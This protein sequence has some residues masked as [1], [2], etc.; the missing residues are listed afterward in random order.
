LEALVSDHIDGPRTTADPS[1]DLSDLFVFKNPFDPRRLVL[2]ADVF[3][4]AG[5]TALFSNVANHNIVLRRIRVAG[6]G[7]ATSFVPEGPEIRFTFQFETLTPTPSGERGAQKGVCKLPDGQALQ[8]VVGD[9]QGA[10]SDGGAVR[11]F[12]GL[13][14]DPFYI[15]WLLGRDLK[16]VPNYLQ[17]DNVLSM[18]VEFDV[19]RFLQ[20]ENGSLFGAIAETAFRDPSPQ[21]IV[22][23]RFDWIGKP[24]QT[25]LRLNGIAGATDLRDLW[26]QET[27]FAIS[28]ATAP[29][30]RERLTRSLELWD[31]RDGK[32]DWEPDALAAN[33]N[34]FLSDFLLFDVAKPITDASHLEIEKSTVDGRPYA[35]GGGR[36]LDANSIDIMV[37][38]LV[39]HDRGPFMQGGAPHA[40]KPGGQTFPYVQPPNT[41][42]LM[43]SRSV[44]LAVSPRDVWS[45]VGKF[46]V[47]TWHPLVATVV[48][49]GI[50][51]GQVR[52]VD[53]IDG[54]VII[55]RLKSIDDGK[56]QLAY[57]LVSGLP[58]TH[59]E[60]TIDVQ[61]K[62]SGATVTWQVRYR[63]DGLADLFVRTALTGLLTAGL[64]NLK[65]RF[66]AA[67]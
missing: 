1:I 59:Y 56:M 5:E 15:G 47:L 38:W 50:G 39:N 37:T 17:E 28:E 14:S 30:Y 66:G 21:Q 33:V 24:E 9:E 51:I 22:P 20:T 64:G 35:T 3:P 54:K 10:S 18:V 26:N 40:T 32:V 63:P 65:A 67:P 6:I 19:G 36:T 41:S 43:I 61:P 49:T 48:T 16:S 7:G 25:N 45:V 2:V 42:L 13:R 62:G 58:A 57:T 29:L 52:N 44:D 34:M 55:E 8:I 27:P 12:A 53:T 46:D 11:A 4:A 31:S 60:A 23:P